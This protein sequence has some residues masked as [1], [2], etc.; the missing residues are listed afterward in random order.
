MKLQ[1]NIDMNE[2]DY[3]EFLITKIGSNGIKL[4]T[5]GLK[6]LIKLEHLELVIG[7]Y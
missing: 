2:Q 3:E 5:E 1:I 7:E 4:I 6:N